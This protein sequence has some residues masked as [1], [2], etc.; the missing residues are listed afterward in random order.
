MKKLEEFIEESFKCAEDLL[1]Y[2]AVKNN[3]TSEDLI[4]LIVDLAVTCIHISYQVEHTGNISHG[5]IHEMVDVVENI[6][7]FK[8][9]ERK[10][11]PYLHQCIKKLTGSVDSIIIE[12][13][14]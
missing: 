5:L 14:K 4:F 1:K 7:K 3:N 9:E 2:V 12:L 10:V 11:S 8:E 6:M 13:S